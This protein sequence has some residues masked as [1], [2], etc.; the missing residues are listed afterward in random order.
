MASRLPVFVHGLDHPAGIGDAGG[1]RLLDHDVQPVRR[2]RLDRVRHARTSPSRRWRDR[3]G[4]PPGRHRGRRR[5]APRGC[6]KCAMALSIRARSGSKMPAIS[7][8]GCSATWRSRSPI[9]MWSKLMPSTPYFATRQLPGSSARNLPNAHRL[10]WHKN[11]T[12]QKMEMRFEY[13]AQSRYF[14]PRIEAAHPI[15]E[16]QNM[17]YATADGHPAR[18]VAGRNGRGRARRLHRRRAPAGDASRRPDCAGCRR[19]VVRSRERRGLGRRDRPCA[20]PQLCRLPRHGAR[21]GGA[22]GRHRGGRHRDAQS[23]ACAGGD[24]LS[25]GRHRRDLRQAAVDHAR[26]GR[27]AGGAGRGKASANSS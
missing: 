4:S 5:P 9:C 2:D 24:G 6:R 25:R 8:S 3:P 20:R 27:G 18:P 22:A 19:A 16:E 23:S 12:M 11:F 1:K 10:A 17:V 7:A 21:R 15:Q 26:R 14:A 13:A